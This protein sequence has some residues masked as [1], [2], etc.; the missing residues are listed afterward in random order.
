MWTHLEVPL[1]KSFKSYFVDGK[2]S[3]GTHGVR[4]LIET[5]LHKVLKIGRLL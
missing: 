5:V 1:N 3:C 2:R 4:L